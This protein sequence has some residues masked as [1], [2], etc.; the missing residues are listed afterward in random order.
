MSNNIILTFEINKYNNDNKYN[1]KLNI[2]GK[3]KNNRIY[4]LSTK[5]SYIELPEK[6]DKKLYLELMIPKLFESSNC[7]SKIW[8]TVDMKN[9]IGFIDK[10]LSGKDKVFPAEL[11]DENQYIQSFSL[12]TSKPV[13]VSKIILY[14]KKTKNK[15]YRTEMGT[16]Y[17]DDLSHEKYFSS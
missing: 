14:I 4:H 10:A 16:Y 2:D 17:Y 7:L 1:Y 9:N 12:A 5:K 13:Y 15:Y 11:N 8:S 6:T 3:I